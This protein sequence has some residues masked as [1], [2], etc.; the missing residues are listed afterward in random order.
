MK[1]LVL[2]TGNGYSW[3][4]FEP[5]VRSLV[6]YVPNTDLVLFVENISEFTRSQ[7][8]SVGG[9]RVKL[10]SPPK[11]LKCKMTV[12]YRWEIFSKYMKRH[13]KD[14]SLVFVAGTRDVIFQGDLFERFS[15]QKNF[16]GYS[17][18][19][20]YP[21]EGVG[22]TD[23]ERANYI[24]IE[25][26]FGTEAADKLAKK[27]CAC[28]D[29][30]I[31]TAEEMCL[32]CEKIAE[33]EVMSSDDEIVGL[34]QAAYNYILHNNLI[35]V[36]NI[37]QIDY[38]GE[39][40][41]CPGSDAQTEKNFILDVDGKVPRAIHQYDRIPRLQNF[42]NENCHEKIFKFNKKYTDTQSAYEQLLQLVYV[43]N[44]EQAAE[45][46]VSF[47]VGEKDFSKLYFDGV[48]FRG[49]FDV[50]ID[51]WDNLI[52]QTSQP[53][54]MSIEILELA[55]QNLLMG[56]IQNKAI[57]FDMYVKQILE[58]LV[59]A[60]EK[61][62]VVSNSFRQ[63]V[64]DFALKSAA[65]AIEEKDFATCSN[66]LDFAEFLGMPLTKDYFV[67]RAGLCLNTGK[68]QE[69]VAFFEKS[70]EFA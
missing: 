29:T 34:D 58:T 69:A 25:R 56:A 31:G 37:I 68:E 64:Y 67:L 24:W 43:G 7:L 61:N 15:N 54:S 59:K 48:Y 1:N 10:E 13:Y 5:F 49:Y 18:S 20:D 35:N 6:K 33:I 30:V 63:F 60:I 17:G 39:D 11:D 3:W 4:T 16:I 50:V 45:V 22:D 52:S 28:A 27:P 70:K 9:G 12:N 26:Y 53:P 44:L 19:D 36:K 57:H 2:G 46:F 51:M 40:I 47:L 65:R 38:D 8:K 41:F 66:N 42:V 55:F 21:I 23:F 32:L 62:H 14:Y